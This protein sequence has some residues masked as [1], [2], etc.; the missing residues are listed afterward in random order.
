MAPPIDPMTLSIR[1][2]RRLLRREPGS[3]RPGCPSVSGRL[4]VA[5]SQGGHRGL[6][7]GRLGLV[8]VLLAAG[9]G[10]AEPVAALDASTGP[11]ISP[12]AISQSLVPAPGRLDPS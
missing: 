9:C 11:A 10:R 5:S 6:A 2:K 1:H 8:V 4:T 12:S 3:R 7:G